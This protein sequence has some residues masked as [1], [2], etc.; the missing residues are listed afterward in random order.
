MN[1]KK[2]LSNKL[3]E[4]ALD[5]FAKEDRNLYQKHLHRIGLVL[6]VLSLIALITTPF[7]SD[8][9][10]ERNP[11]VET[12]YLA[13]TYL[14]PLLVGFLAV[15]HARRERW[16]IVLLIITGV[17]F[18]AEAVLLVAVNGSIDSMVGPYVLLIGMC[19][20]L[21]LLSE[22]RSKKWTRI[23]R[24]KPRD[25]DLR[26]N[27]RNELFDPIVMAP[28]LEVKRSV[29]EA[30]DRFLQAEEEETPLRITIHS[31]VSISASLQELMIEGFRDHYADE[32]AQV[33]RF[34]EIRFTRSITLITIG[35][36]VLSLLKN[37]PSETN[38]NT[39]W[40]IAS[41]Y[42]AFSLWQVGSTYFERASMIPKLTRIVIARNAEISFR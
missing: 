38:T 15:L 6:I 17:C 42:A 31:A 35:I 36:M 4:K 18:A 10:E 37:L 9:I 34:L 25:L 33:N 24:R 5:L 13:V 39:V 23:L 29:I 27:G 21:L 16:K 12:E 41:N 1:P 30:V 26:I 32:E 2:L 14:I 20:Y 11:E 3:I 19:F 8:A 7:F 22:S 40:T 28:H